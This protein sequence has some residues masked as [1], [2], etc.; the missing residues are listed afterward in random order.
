MTSPTAAFVQLSLFGEVDPQIDFSFEDLWSSSEMEKA[1]VREANANTDKAYIDAGVVSALEVRKKVARDH[2]MPYAGLDLDD[3]PELSEME[4]SENATKMATP[5]L[6]AFTEGI[7]DKGQA[8]EEL[9]ENG[10]FKTITE[11]DIQEAKDAPPE[12]GPQFCMGLK[13]VGDP[14]GALFLEDHDDPPSN[15]AENAE[16]CRCSRSRPA[17]TDSD[18]V[19]AQMHSQRCNSQLA[20]GREKTERAAP[21][22]LHSRRAVRSMEPK[23]VRSRSPLVRSTAGD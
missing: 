22:T 15:S 19:P 4:K 14:A 11:E 1:Q 5:I 13:P 10:V 16:S 3:A 20:H 2:D 23:Q 18:G 21:A 12:L 6:Q 17:G 7:L 8:L 9:V